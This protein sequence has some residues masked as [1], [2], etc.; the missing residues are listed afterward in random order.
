MVTR[1]FPASI[2]ARFFAFEQNPSEQR[3]GELAA[4]RDSQRVGLE[5]WLSDELRWS[6]GQLRGRA[7]VYAS[8][9]DEHGKE[10][11]SQLGGGVT[12]RLEHA[13]VVAGGKLMPMAIELAGSAGST[14]DEGWSRLMGGLSIGLSSSGRGISI[15]VDAGTTGSGA[16]WPEQFE[17]GGVRSS[18]L[19][20]AAT[21]NHVDVSALP[22]GILRGTSFDSESIS[23]R[24]GAGLPR[25][26]AQRV[27]A[28]VESGDDA[29][30]LAGLEWT[31][32]VDAMPV[33]RIP[34]LEL[35]AGVAQV[36]DEGLLEGDTSVW[37]TM[38]W[39]P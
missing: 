1:Q 28:D 27:S 11:I 8:E 36:L 15:A 12:A 39:K 35:R 37:L 24:P 26:F 16:P 17:I 33:A 4:S 9:I 29:I 5:A 13:P 6:G 10:S 22:A 32:D 19:P 14:D 21:S 18:I 25:L 38:R 2:G 31:F 23:L 7:S 30:S 3:D 34:A 20:D